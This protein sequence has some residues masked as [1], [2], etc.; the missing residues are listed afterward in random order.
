MCE[1]NSSQDTDVSCSFP[2][3]FMAACVR[4]SVAC[5]MS[6]VAVLTVILSI[7]LSGT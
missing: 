7:Q 4:E 2:E 5:W 1:I 6:V 3:E